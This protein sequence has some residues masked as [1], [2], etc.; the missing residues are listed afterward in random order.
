MEIDEV[1]K[2]HVLNAKEKR[3]FEASWKHEKV[4]V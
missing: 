1:L 4:V 3:V 2:W